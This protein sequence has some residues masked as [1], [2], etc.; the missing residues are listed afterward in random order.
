M[1]DSKTN[2]CSSKTGWYFSL[3]LT[4]PGGQAFTC[5]NVWISG[6]WNPHKKSHRAYT[7][8][9]IVKKCMSI[10]SSACWGIMEINVLL[11][12]DTWCPVRTTANTTVFAQ[13][14]VISS[15]AAG[16]S[17]VWGW[18]CIFLILLQPRHRTRAGCVFFKSHPSDRADSLLCGI[19]K[20]CRR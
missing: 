20:P 1:F 18:E 3:K 4:L 7:N 12:P 5:P 11:A 2:T 19:V 15:C 13:L 9:W 17:R 16:A 6:I 10:P 14:K 8:G